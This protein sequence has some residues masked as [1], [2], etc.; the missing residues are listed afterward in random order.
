[1]NPLKIE[2]VLARGQGRE[3]LR[4]RTEDNLADYW[5]D[6]VKGTVT[7]PRK[8][9]I[10]WYGEEFELTGKVNEEVIPGEVEDK[11]AEEGTA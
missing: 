1:M 11:T 10:P 4:E 5:V 7:V 6:Y 9:P 2:A 8:T 3:S